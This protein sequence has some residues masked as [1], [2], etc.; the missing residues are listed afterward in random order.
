MAAPRPIAAPPLPAAPW[1]EPPARGLR[2]FASGVA[3]LLHGGLAGL[4]LLS[5]ATPPSP[6]APEV[7]PMTLALAEP[8]VEEA[9]APAADP[10][11]EPASTPD[12][13][14]A[15][16][17]PPPEPAPPEPPPPEPTPAEPEPAEPVQEEPP[18]PEPLPE[19]SPEPP[20]PPRPEPPPPPR[21]RPAAPRPAPSRP[22]ATAPAAAQPAPPAPAQQ[23]AGPPPSYLQAV[24]A[25]L[26]RQKRY[27]EAARARRAVGVALLHFTLRRDGRVAAWRILRSA[28]DA[29]LDSA[30]EAMIQRASLPAMPAEMD[31]DSLA[32]TVPVRFQ[33]R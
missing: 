4:L 33:L 20:P 1:P 10:A 28:G 13:A 22:V 21:P 5:P 27:P 12:P 18:P 3:V 25:A 7:V 11:P 26:E 24:A 6:A 19:P 16:E 29:D 30:V 32:I 14:P 31:G 17:P 8:V 2:L 23:A 15:A 9:P